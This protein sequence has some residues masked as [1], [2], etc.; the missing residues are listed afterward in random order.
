MLD[1]GQAAFSLGCASTIVSLVAIEACTRVLKI[2]P[3][4]F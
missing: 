3:V 1:A 2:K 4:S